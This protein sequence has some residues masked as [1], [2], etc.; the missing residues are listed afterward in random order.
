MANFDI[1]SGGGRDSG[2]VQAIEFNANLRVDVEWGSDR[3][4]DRGKCRSL[5]GCW[6]ID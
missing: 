1:P 3:Y 4:Q 5:E 2:G 6:A